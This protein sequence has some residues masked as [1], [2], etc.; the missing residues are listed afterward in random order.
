MC[1]LSPSFQEWTKQNLWKT[2]FEKFEEH[3]PSNFLKAV[4][5]KFYLVHSWILCPIYNPAKYLKSNLPKVDI[6]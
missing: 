6:L 4:F 2:A 1:H 3:I 5:H